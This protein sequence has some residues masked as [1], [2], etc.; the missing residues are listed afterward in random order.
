MKNPPME[1]RKCCYHLSPGR[2]T[3][4]SAE[5]REGKV[6]AAQI[7]STLPGQ[8]LDAFLTT[9]PNGQNW[10]GMISR[11]RKDYSLPVRLL[12]PSRIITATEQNLAKY[13]LSLASWGCSYVLY[14][15]W[16]WQPQK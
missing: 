6:G 7:N 5:R 12:Y 11:R 4:K 9:A 2:A 16:E 8:S 3:E 10:P 13:I 15:P 14:T 1:Y